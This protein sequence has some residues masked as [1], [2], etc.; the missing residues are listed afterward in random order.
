MVKKLQNAYLIEVID[1]RGVFSVDIVGDIAIGLPCAELIGPGGNAEV[2]VVSNWRQGTSQLHSS[3][4]TGFC[5]PDCPAK[6]ELFKL[7]L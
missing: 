5:P 4:L 2:G 1:P 7:A 6:K 3:C